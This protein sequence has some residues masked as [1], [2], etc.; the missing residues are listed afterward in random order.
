MAAGPDLVNRYANLRALAGG[1]TESK[2]GMLF[3]QLLA[4]ALQR[5]GIDAECDARGPRGEVDVAFAYDGTWYL[6]EVKWEVEPINADPVRK[7]HDVLDERRPGSMGILA[8]RS[9][10]NDSALRRAVGVRNIILFDRSHIEALL[11]GVA[12]AHEIIMAA[13]RSISV[14]G[15]EHATLAALLRP[16][17]PIETPVALGVP[18]GFTPASVA[19]PNAL[20]ADV[21]AYGDGIK[22]LA[23]HE[24]RLLIAVEDGVVELDLRRSR[25]RRRLELTNC[26]GNAFVENDGSVLVA[27]RGGIARHRPDAVEAA[28]GGF[29]RTP[30]IVPG[31]DGAPWFLD[32]S[33]TGWPGSQ[34]GHLVAPRAHLGD[35]QRYSCEFPAASCANVCWMREHTFLVL[36]DGHS[37]IVDLR[38]RASTRL[39][40]PVGRPH[41]LIRLN[42]TWALV[43]GSNRHLQTA[44]IN[45]ESG[46]TSEPI[47]VNLAGHVGDAVMIDRF[48]FVVA[49]AP[50]SS[51]IVVPVVAR[52]PIDDLTVGRREALPNRR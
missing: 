19:A 44:L 1:I 18:E 35:D 22:G 7:L 2:R 25:A 4:D 41:G 3:N 38:T 33:T 34:P 32:R 12:T 21:L 48:V 16:R 14:F 9:G 30:M 37:C 29:T 15:H 31:I 20:D 6:L 50:V 8:S 39:V 43:T 51:S 5:D 10:F 40:T 27:R 17:R 24:A 45:T 47:A 36:G 49:G 11:T 23:S 42:D 52:L 46:L 13:N 26:E 28:A